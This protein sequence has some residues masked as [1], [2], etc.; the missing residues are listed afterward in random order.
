MF[1]QNEYESEISEETLVQ[2]LKTP[3]VHTTIRINTLITNKESF[4]E[5]M[6]EALLMVLNYI[7]I[8]VF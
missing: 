3:P 8:S 6:N 2:H 4:K 5:E 1:L 7:L